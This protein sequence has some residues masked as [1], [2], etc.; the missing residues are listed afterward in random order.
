MPPKL[1]YA[2]TNYWCLGSPVVTVF[3]DGNHA[4]PM[5]NVARLH[6]VSRIKDTQ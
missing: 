2:S 3:T 5:M 4:S 1:N 6:K